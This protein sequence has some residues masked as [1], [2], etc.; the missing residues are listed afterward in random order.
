VLA[1]A[2]APAQPHIPVLHAIVLGITQGLSEF[3]PISSS[4]HLILV[5]W[6]F[7]WHELDNF[8]DLNKTFDVALHAGTFI[9]AVAYFWR[10]LSRLIPAGLRA[11]A[12]R[13]IQTTE[14]R[15]AWLL[16]LS[17]VPGA[18]VGALFEKVIEDNLGQP[19]LIATM[20]IVF[21]LVLYVSDRAAQ[22][23][24]YEDFGV[25]H[26]VI[27]GV[28][29]AAALQPGVSRSGVTITVGRFLGFERDD[30]ARISFLMSIPI[31]GGAAVYKG[32]KLVRDGI[33]A[34][35]G[36]AFFWGVLAS[37]VTGLLA[38][39]VVFRIVKSRSYTPFV[40]YRVFA[41]LAVLGIIL[42]GFRP[43]S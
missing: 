37:A 33:P 29:Q 10:D 2:A 3:F 17:A 14:E 32:A 23:L 38:I 11:A 9:G 16:L 12:R 35:T 15:L 31:I 30:V 26:A 28:A 4:G 27:M 13:S 34:G 6:L 19:W 41:G 18:I 1:A 25:R 20:L 5:P 21:G 22:R 24:K 36:G 39:Y 40:V 42:S 43:A 8:K 7:N